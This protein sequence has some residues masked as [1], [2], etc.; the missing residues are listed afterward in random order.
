M[1]TPWNILPWTEVRR[2]LEPI[3]MG[4]VEYP[5]LVSNCQSIADWEAALQHNTVEINA[6]DE[7]GMNGMH[8]A[9]RRGNLNLVKY[10]VSRNA[11]LHKLTEDARAATSLHLAVESGDI[12]T[13]QFLVGKGLPIEATDS[14]G[15]TSA[16]LAIRTGRLVQV[17]YLLRSNP[18]VVDIQDNE[19][20]TPLHTAILLG[21]YNCMKQVMAH[22]P[23][24]YIYDKSGHLPIHQTLRTSNPH[25]LMLLAEYDFNQFSKTTKSGDRLLGL[26]MET[27]DETIIKVVRQYTS[28]TSFPSWF[29]TYMW[30][31][32]S[33]TWVFFFCFM[34]FIINFW[35]LLGLSIFGLRT[36]YTL[37]QSEH[38]KTSKNPIIASGV[39]AFSSAGLFSYVYWVFPYASAEH[40]FLSLLVLPA[41]ILSLELFRR[42]YF[43]DPGYHNY[44]AE[45][46]VAFALEAKSDPAPPSLC[47][48]CL[49]TRPIRTKH[50]SKCERCIEGEQHHCIVLNSCIAKNNHGTFLAFLASSAFTL[51]I[52]LAFTLPYLGYIIPDDVQLNWTNVYA[53]F[54]V[55][56]DLNGALSLLSILA[57]SGLC[58]TTFLLLFHARLIA[59]NLTAYESSHWTRYD[60]MQNENGDFFNP[61][62][63]GIAQNIRDFSNTWIG[64]SRSDNTKAV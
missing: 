21:S 64:S 58:Y 59:Y 14:A 28:M 24:V 32:S 8:Y 39:L 18:S 11:D 43:R 7:R 31:L 22:H 29:K 36:L 12:A 47:E 49:G 62:D 44:S 23:N 53:T 55:F 42:V 13:L 38:F 2:S 15:E 5:T 9:V 41:Y 10:L 26:A 16:H 61:N 6:C 54:R 56:F 63:K 4:D 37:T 57:I 25:A 51:L 40:P 17:T 27:G 60:Y 50:C 46:T 45:D 20:R 3:P 52:W 33:A 35:L 30:H 48:S 1:H 19:G 34:C